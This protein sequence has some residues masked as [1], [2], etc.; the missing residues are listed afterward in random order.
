MRTESSTNDSRLISLHVHMDRTTLKDNRSCSR[1]KNQSVLS[2]LLD[3]YYTQKE[4]SG[5]CHYNGGAEDSTST[6]NLKGFLSKFGLQSF[7]PQ[8]A[9]K[10]YK[11]RVSSFFLIPDACFERTLNFIKANPEQKKMF[12]QLRKELMS[13]KRDNDAFSFH[14]E[15][16]QLFVK[17][18]C[19]RNGKVKKS[20]RLNSCRFVSNGKLS[21]F[22]NLAISVKPKIRLSMR[23]KL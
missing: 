2:R 17:C 14:Q 16:G 15:G 21:T 20:L 6:A 10:G 19:C 4:A 13:L 12:E 1:K 7:Y 8:L 11:E 5:Y 9:Q 23:S 22:A 3:Q 18:Q